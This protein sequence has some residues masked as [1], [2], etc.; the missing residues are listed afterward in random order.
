MRGLD[1]RVSMAMM[2]AGLLC[3]V[4]NPAAAEDEDP[5]T[6]SGGTVSITFE[7][8]IFGDEDRDYTNGIRLDYISERNEL[9]LIGRIARRNLDWL[10]DAD[11]WYMTYAVGQNIFTPD[12][13][14]LAVP[15]AGERPYAG[16]LYGGIGLAADSGETLDVIALELGVVGPAALA[17]QTQR[18]V[19]RT[20]NAQDPQGWDTQLENEPAFRFVYERKYQFEQDLSLSF[21]DLAADIA[22]HVNV[23]LGTVDTSG[24]AGATMRLGQDL[25]DDYGPPRIRPAVSAPG[26][27]R[28][29]DGFSWYIF[30]GIEGRVVGYNTFIQGNTFGGVDGVDPIRLVADFQAGAAVQING[31]ELAYTHVIRT[32]EYE[33]QD[34]LSEFGSV[35]LRFKF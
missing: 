1:V 33:G 28:D 8:D 16:F 3:G 26:F 19:H 18:F 22:P 4:I 21:L 30:A 25:A 20:I 2:W 34:G 7:N 27:F 35:N 32:R 17:E 5:A 29:Q 13:I 6:S 12:D 24:G 31:V 15:P 23:S 10:T 11:D 14:S 9:P